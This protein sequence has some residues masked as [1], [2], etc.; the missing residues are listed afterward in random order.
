MTA[1]IATMITTIIVAMG[2]AIGTTMV[3]AGIATD[4]DAVWQPLREHP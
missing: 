1:I 2:D 4:P 3:A